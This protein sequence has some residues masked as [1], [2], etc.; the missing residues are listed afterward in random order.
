MDI[1]DVMVE[2]VTAIPAEGAH[3]REKGACDAPIQAG[4]ALPAG[5]R[6]VRLDDQGLFDFEN[7]LW[8]GKTPPFMDC[9]VI[10]NT[11]FGKDGSLDL[12]NVAVIPIEARQL[13]RKRL[14]WGDII[15]ERSGGG[16]KQPVGRVAFFDLQAGNF[17]F[18]N[19]TSRLRVVATTV[20]DPEWLHK[21]LL[22]FHW[23][24]QTE[25]MQHRTTGIR[26]LAFEDYRKLSIPLPPLPEQRAIARALRG[27]RD[28]IQARRREA[29]LERER[30]AA[31]MQHLFTHGT[32]G[33]PTRQTEI[34]EMPESWRVVRLGTLCAE[35]KGLIQT[36]PFGSQLHATDY[37]DAG[38][39]VVN[40]THLGFNTIIEDH[41][42]LITKD[43]ADRLER[44]YLEIGDILISRRGDFS[45]YSYISHAHVGWICGTGCL[46][47]R[48]QNHDVDNF[49]MSISM[50]TPPVQDYFRQNAVGSIMPNLNTK[51]LEAMPLALPSLPEQLTIGEAINTC[52]TKIAALER[53]TALLEELF[54]ALLEE[55]MTGR[56]R[57]PLD[58]TVE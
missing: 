13:N 17:C 9:A 45:R 51:I 23:S 4:E 21:Y 36:G 41:V 34:G 39:P 57:V 7:G 10:R 28:A 48:L 1:A 11:N 22:Y 38:V 49:F 14:K 56:L 20:V 50:S 18:S 3:T 35:G 46:L 42:P 52:G 58:S 16:P 30:K 5:W 15:I 43:D 12:S 53:E 26:N 40:P 25:R 27:V 6:R 8:M 54:R 19:F 29:A 2:D 31:L 33:E 32:R 47:I 37:K 44:H 24:G 55:L